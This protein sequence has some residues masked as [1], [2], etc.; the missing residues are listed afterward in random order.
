M[1]LV[2]RVSFYKKLNYRFGG[3]SLSVNF[4]FTLTD[5]FSLKVTLDRDRESI[6]VRL[7]DVG[8]P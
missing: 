5:R 8:E 3:L 6:K 7:T 1:Y 4:A 2:S